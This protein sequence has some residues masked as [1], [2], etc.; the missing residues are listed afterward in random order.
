MNQFRALA[1]LSFVVAT[2]GAGAAAIAQDAPT[3]LSIGNF[4]DVTSWDPSLADIGFDGPYLSAVYDPLVALDVTGK[5]IPVLATAWSYSDDFLTLT[6][7]LRAGVTFSDGVAFDAQAAAANL[8]YLKAGAR[9]G[10]AY[11]NV[12]GI[13]VVDADTI[14]IALGE[15]DD[16]M[17]YLMGLGRSY[18]ASPA[19]IAAGTLVTAPVGSGPYLLDEGMSVAG[20]EYHFTKVA[21]HWDSA[22]YPFQNITIFPIIDQAA[23]HNAMLS[24]QINVNFAD[25]LNLEQAKQMGWNITSGVSAWVGL[26]FVD[27]MGA[28][29][30]PLGDVRVR[31]ALNYAFDG[32]A[33][34]NSLGAGAGQVT[35]QVFPAGQK[36]NNPALNA[37]Y[38]FNLDKAKALL[39]EAGYADGFDVSMPMSPIFALWQPVV[40]QTFRELGIRVTWD[41]MQMMDYQVNAPNYPM[42]VALVAMDNDPVAT[43][44]RQ[45]ATRQW[46]NPAP[47]FAEV[48]ELKALIE[49][50][51]AAVGDEQVAKI[52]AANRK[53]TELAWWSVWYQADNTY[54]SI[55]EIAVM[56]VIGMMFPTL[57][58]IQKTQ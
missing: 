24:G 37:L 18:M 33:I 54:Y 22:T 57:R 49:D 36:G 21:E 2:L 53:L 31:Q 25:P 41:D 11:L 8:N 1:A 7:D 45:V 3:D 32:A 13:T 4:L 48:P 42:F 12:T 39:A 15:R 43:L 23:R 20:S 58:S 40:D 38:A 34:L 46:Y 29:L 14:E 26:Q 55:P 27:H 35:N 9:S 44:A 6:M 56:P 52:A 16:T 5:P 51:L 50:A 17:L 28:S 10:E 30:A 47:Q 19:A